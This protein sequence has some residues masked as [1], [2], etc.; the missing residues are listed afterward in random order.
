M[1]YLYRP[2]LKD[3][4]TGPCHHPDPSHA[5]EKHP[6]H[7][8]TDVCPGCGARFSPVW[9]M[10][11]YDN[12][13]AIRESTETT[14]E[15]KA[16]ER[17]KSCEGKVADGQ[18]V[19]PKVSKILYD[20]LAADLRTHYQTTGERDLKEADG[21]FAHLTPF[22]KLRRASEIGSADV[23]KYIAAGQA[24]GAANGTISQELGV[25]GRM[26][27]VAYEGEAGPIED[28]P[29][30]LPAHGRAEPGQPRRAGARGDEGHGPQDPQ[31]VRPLSH[32]EP[33]GPTG[34]G[35]KADGHVLGRV[36]RNKKGVALA[37][38]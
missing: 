19:K 28:D 7:G 12:G 13:K 34:G 4:A 26:F 22:F 24:E 9:W 17:L 25:L 5:G 37:T 2:R 11:Y 32:R 6:E 33:G 8:R 21:G 36:T 14:K 30:R 29:A 27:R 15:T 35:A 38:P 31:R 16:K 23:T 18:P 3:P 10:K 1:G 20:E